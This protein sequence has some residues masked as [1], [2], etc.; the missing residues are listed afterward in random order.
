MQSSLVYSHDLN[1]YDLGTEHALRPERVEGAVAMMR[2]HDLLGAAGLNVIEPHPAGRE[3][4]ERVHD[5]AYIDAV[6]RASALGAP[7]DLSHG[8]GAGDTPV[9]AGMHTAAAL[10]AGGSI[11]AMRAVLEGGDTRSLAIAGGLHH[12]HRDRAAGFCVYNDPAAAI[13]WALEREP[14]MRIAYIDID[15]HH[16]DGVQET[17]WNEPRVLTVS[18]H[19]SGRYLFPGT[20]FPDERGGPLAKDS[21]ANIPL[22]Q[23][24]TDACYD[25]A[26]DAAV[27]PLV[28]RFRPD[29]IV[30]Q[31]GADALHSDPLTSLG[32]TLGGYRMLVERISA[33]SHRLCEGRLV[34]L[35][36]G[37]YDWQEMVPRAWTLLA[38]SLL[39]REMPASLTE[40][41]G[42]V[43]REGAEEHL[44]RRTREVVAEVMRGR[45]Y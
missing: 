17:F 15:A 20:G 4:L 33:L 38:A 8:I 27:A 24:A 14:R 45:E 7:D 2:S 23:Y 39:G 44:L 18:L 10:V 43:L 19:E 1:A 34:A 11:E 32:L 5:A 30:S 9:F 3:D 31:N 40:G 29:L 16:G 26:F 36:G 37:G 12:A 6:I 42:P 41:A 35:G 28:S 25:F 22:P 21:A 13:A